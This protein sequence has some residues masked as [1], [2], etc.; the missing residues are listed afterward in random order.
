[1]VVE[2]QVREDVEAAVVTRVFLPVDLVCT[3]CGY[4]AVARRGPLSCPMC[5][6]DSWEPAAWRPFTARLDLDE[7]E[8]A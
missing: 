1:V 4:G 8:L 6:S 7:V 2:L 3:V 5:R